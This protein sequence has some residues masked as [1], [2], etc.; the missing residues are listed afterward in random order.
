MDHDD[1]GGDPVDGQSPA[2][3]ALDALDD[4]PAST[5]FPCIEGIAAKAGVTPDELIRSIAVAESLTLE[6]GVTATTNFATDLAKIN[7]N[8]GA[9][10]SSQLP[11]LLA[12]IAEDH[13]RAY[14]TDIR[15]IRR[16]LSMSAAA[17]SPDR[18]PDDPDAALED[19]LRDAFRAAT[20]E[21]YA[22]IT[23]LFSALYEQMLDAWGHKP[24]A[25][26]DCV[27]IATVFTALYEGLMLRYATDDAMD[28]ESAVRLAGIGIRT[29]MTAMTAGL[30]DDRTIEQLFVDQLGRPTTRAADTATDSHM[31]DSQPAEKDS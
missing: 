4:A 20:T 29:F 17:L 24:R 25:P 21:S 10:P 13:F 7:A 12:V 30:D 2:D 14:A 22:Q 27:T 15:G 26:I 16:I 8:I 3:A 31:T 19:G 11:M 5:M 23:A 1:P 6:S 18:P 28:I 9:M